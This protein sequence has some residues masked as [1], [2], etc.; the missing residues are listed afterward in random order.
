MHQD[1]CG[2]SCISEHDMICLIANVICENIGISLT[3]KCLKLKVANDDSFCRST[4]TLL[5]TSQALCE[6]YELP[7]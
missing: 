1:E 4:V 2:V 6:P 3:R 5:S 7:E